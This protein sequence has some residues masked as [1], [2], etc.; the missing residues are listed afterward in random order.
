M[1]SPGRFRRG[2]VPRQLLHDGSDQVLSRQQP[3]GKG[4]RKPSRAEQRLCR[5][6]LD[7]ELT[8]VRPRLLLAVGGLAIETLLG[9][10]T[11]LEEAVGLSL[12]W[13]GGG[14]CLCRTHLVQACGPTCRRTS[15]GCGRRWHCCAT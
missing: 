7:R 9:R 3:H 15:P 2:Y 14:S 1:A 13:T 10:P 12:R 8:L 5:P 6:F 4:D 11:R